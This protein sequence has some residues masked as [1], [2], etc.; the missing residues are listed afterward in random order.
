MS[1]VAEPNGLPFLSRSTLAPT[2]MHMLVR[3]MVLV[4]VLVLSLQLAAALVLA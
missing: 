4:L 1:K 2:S 3:V